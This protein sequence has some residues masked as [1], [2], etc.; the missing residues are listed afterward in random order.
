MSEPLFVFTT[1]RLLASLSCAM[2]GNHPDMV[3]LAE[4]NLFTA[5]TYVELETVY[6]IDQRFQHGLLR[7]IAEFGLGGQTET[8]IEL[9]QSWLFDNESVKTIDI[10]KDIMALVEPRHVVDTSILYVYRPGVI[11]RITN[12]F[13]DAYY[14]HL[15]L[16]PRYTC[17]MIHKTRKLA[18]DTHL[19]R[20]AGRDIALNPDDM[21]LKPHIHILNGLENISA[22]HKM[23]L[24][25][26]DLLSDPHPN[27]LKIA[28]WLGVRTDQESIDAMMRPDES[29]FANYGPENA[30][31]G[32]DPHFLENPGLISISNQAMDLEAPMSWDETLVLDDDLKEL[33]S[34]LGYG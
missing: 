3:G 19:G 22:T 32:N 24:R 25:G 31:L 4:T 30:S 12:A 34:Y 6:L 7:T 26:E 13:P 5:E 9:A 10:F 8:N 23:F 11:N 2:I 29:P 15:S 1:P 28:E 16:N 18:A 33:A 21:W 20:Q 14:L 27:L 17:E